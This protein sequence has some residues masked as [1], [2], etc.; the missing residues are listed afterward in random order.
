MNKNFSQS[1]FETA[2]IAGCGV[3]FTNGMDICP[4]ELYYNSENI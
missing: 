2:H 3:A 4:D 1:T